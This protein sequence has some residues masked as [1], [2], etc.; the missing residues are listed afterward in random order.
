MRRWFEVADTA[1]PRG[2]ADRRAGGRRRSSPAGRRPSAPCGRPGWRTPRPPSWTPPPRWSTCVGRA[3]P[4]GAPGGHP[5][6]RLHRRG[7]AGPAARAERAGADRDALPL[8][9]AQRRRPA[10]AADRERGRGA[11]STPS[12]SPAPP[13]RWPPC[14]RP[15]RWAGGSAFTRALGVL[16]A[17]RGRGAGDGRPAAGGR[18]RARSSPS[19]TGSGALIRLVCEQLSH[20]P[21]RAVPQRGRAASSSGAAT[22]PS[23]GGRRAGPARAGPVPH[24]GPVGDGGAPRPSWSTRCPSPSTTTPWRSR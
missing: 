11:S 8:G 13:A 1:G 3:G 5:A 2:G 19:A 23:T 22:S 17:R 15:R 12:S 21:R 4:D 7:P 18:R 16:G 10:A 6:A 20:A 24:P 9:A 14:G